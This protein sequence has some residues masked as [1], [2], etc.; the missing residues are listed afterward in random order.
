MEFSVLSVHGL[1]QPINFQYLIMAQ[2]MFAG[3]QK[4]KTVIHMAVFLHL[5][6]T[7]SIERCTCIKIYFSALL[8][9]Y[10]EGCSVFHIYLI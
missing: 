3:T 1:S 4:S 5:K 9:D 2:A 10:L 8:I 6:V 7:N